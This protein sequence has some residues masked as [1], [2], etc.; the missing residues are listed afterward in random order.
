MKLEDED[1]LDKEI[2]SIKEKSKFSE[3]KP[4]ET[5]TP[6]LPPSASRSIQRGETRTDAMSASYQHDISHNQEQ[7][8]DLKEE[9][10]E[11][12]IER[13]TKKKVPHKREKLRG[14]KVKKMDN[15]PPK[16]IK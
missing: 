11:D 7:L 3:E 12:E 9:N 2:A 15:L 1:L 13:V 16:R 8:D 14:G 6:G 4:R 5:N 10:L